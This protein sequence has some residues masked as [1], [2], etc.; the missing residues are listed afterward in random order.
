MIKVNIKKKKKF[1]TQSLGAKKNNLNCQ[2]HIPGWLFQWKQ[3]IIWRKK[4]FP[5]PKRNGD[6]QYSPH[7]AWDDNKTF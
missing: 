3:L 4:L 5:Q 2:E 1:Q 7:L 6:L